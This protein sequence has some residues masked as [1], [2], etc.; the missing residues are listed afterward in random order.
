[1]Y[2]E[3]TRKQIADLLNMPVSTV[4]LYTDRGLIKPSIL[5]KVSRGHARIYSQADVE[6]FK[7]VVMLRRTEMPLRVIQRVLNRS[8]PVDVIERQARKYV[9]MFYTLQAV[10]KG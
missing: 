1:M 5:S 2:K 6:A 10:V 9:D 7:I 4:Q 3:Y 8:E